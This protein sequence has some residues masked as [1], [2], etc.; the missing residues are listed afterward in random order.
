MVVII[1]GDC[2]K[3]QG[4]PPVLSRSTQTNMAGW[5]SNTGVIA[6]VTVKS[7]PFCKRYSVVEAPVNS[8]YFVFPR[9]DRY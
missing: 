1:V 7:D 5:R 4:F 9:Y 6:S 2:R 8:R 3:S